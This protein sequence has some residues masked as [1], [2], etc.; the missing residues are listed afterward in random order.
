MPALAAPEPQ[1][2]PEP[3]APLAVEPEP[4]VVEPTPLAPPVPEAAPEPDKPAVI[5]VVVM[6]LRDGE[7]LEI[8]TFSEAAEASSRAQQVVAQITAAEGEA[9][10]PFFAD[11]YLRPDTIVSVD[12]LE[13]PADKWSGSAIRQR[14]AAAE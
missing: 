8:G 13:E 14:W 10:W 1:P 12:L 2:A 11:R 4:L 7:V 5:N 9:T 3:L 6:R